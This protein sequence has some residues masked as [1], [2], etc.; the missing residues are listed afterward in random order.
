VQQARARIGV[1]LTSML[2]VEIDRLQAVRSR[3]VLATSTWLVDSRAEELGRYV[4]RSRE[5]VDRVVDRAGQQLAEHVGHLRA[6]SPQR[7]LDRGYAI[8]QLPDGSALRDAA[9]A[10]A[11]T[12]L[13]ITLA[14]GSVTAQT[15]KVES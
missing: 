1:R 15:R 6:L 5:L 11:G 10:P 12:D 3:P 4:Q 2:G 7:T 9:D 14:R 13:R 8:A